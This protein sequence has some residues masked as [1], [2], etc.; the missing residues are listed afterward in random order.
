M[1]GLGCCQL[2]NIVGA[3][4]TIAT[5]ATEKLAR[6]MVVK[7]QCELGPDGAELLLNS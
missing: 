3:T 7:R 5:A 6:C 1:K 4:G 2:H